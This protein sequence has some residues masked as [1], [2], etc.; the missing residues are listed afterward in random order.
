MPFAVGSSQ[1]VARSIMN[2]AS[3]TQTDGH[4]FLAVVAVVWLVFVCAKHTRDNNKPTAVRGGY[5]T[6]GS[7]Q[8][9]RC[10]AIDRFYC[11]LYKF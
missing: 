5:S 6:K 9:D 11:E 3:K 8:Q 7:Q 2:N 1:P 10:Y 4:Y